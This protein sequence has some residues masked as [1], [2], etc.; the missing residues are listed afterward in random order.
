VSTTSGRYVSTTSG[1]YVSTTSGR[2][3][4]TTSGRYVSTTSI[5]MW[6]Q[7]LVVEDGSDEVGRSKHKLVCRLDAFSIR[8]IKSHRAV[9]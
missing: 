5:H 2:Y 7:Y 8:E 4:S 3:V 9:K 1:R 6:M